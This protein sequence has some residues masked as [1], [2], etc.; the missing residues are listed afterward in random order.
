MRTKD[1]IFILIV[2]AVFL[3]FIISDTFYD[4]YLSFNAEHGMVMSFLKFG[5][6]ATMGELLGLRISRGVYYFKGFGVLPRAIVWGILGMGINMAFIVF[7]TGVP[8]FA[9]YLGVKDT[10]AILSGALSW[11]KVALAF[12]IS[13][14]LNSIFAP[15]FMTLHKI[16]DTHIMNNGGTLSGLFTPIKMGEIMQ[17][18][19]WKVQWGF[20]FK[21][22][23]PLFWFPA[24]TI[25]FLL[26]GEMRVL[27]AALLGVLLGVILSIAARKK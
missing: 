3:P 5:I 10:A 21:K 8:A 23:I 7:S 14:V 16:T 15:V 9:E 19:N 25:T 22:T 26:P 2:I 24:H 20:V 4:W 18:L 17:N 12:S 13:V 6:L 1:L 27:F 11:Q